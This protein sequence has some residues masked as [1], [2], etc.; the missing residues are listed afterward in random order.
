M[1]HV[2]V[3]ELPTIYSKQEETDTRMVLY[4]H[5][6]AAFAWIQERSSQNPWHKYLRESSLKRPRLQASW[7]YTMISGLGNID[8]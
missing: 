2:E 6:A 1:F 7:L 5:R 4:L 8:N 3:R